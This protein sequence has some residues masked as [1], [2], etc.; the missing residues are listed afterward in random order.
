MRDAPRDLGDR[1]R[2]IRAGRRTKGNLALCDNGKPGRLR[3]RHLMV[4]S[5]TP[6]LTIYYGG[7]PPSDVS[8]TPWW[9]IGLLL[10]LI[11]M[12]V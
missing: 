5:W 9:F 2:R 12:R 10:T 7:R 1:E 4:E 8:G 6:G 3:D 11:P